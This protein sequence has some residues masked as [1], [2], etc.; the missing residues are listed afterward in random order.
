M[1]SHDEFAIA[2]LADV[3]QAFGAGGRAERLPSGEG[4]AFR[5]G[6]LVLKP[7][8]EP[9]EA[10][11]IGNVLED[12]TEKAHQIYNTGVVNTFRSQNAAQG[13]VSRARNSF[14]PVRRMHADEVDTDA[15]LVRR[16]LGAQFPQWA[17]L[18]IMRV[19]SAGTDNAIYR[20]GDDMSV[21]L[22]RIEW[23]T[24]QIPK[25]QHWLP[26]LA[27]HLPVAIP[28]PL[29]QGEPAEGY[30]WTWAVY[31]WLDGENALLEDL[32]DPIAAATA[33]AQF[34]TA[35]QRVDTTGAPLATELP[36]LR[37]APLPSRDQETRAA[38][39]ELEGMYDVD[40][41]TTVWER[42]LAAPPWDRPP[43]WF[44]GD[45]LPGN[46]LF[47]H[48]VLCAVIDFSGLGAGDPACDLM[49]AWALFSGES[50]AAFRAALDLDDATWI[51]ARGHAV[52]Q[53]AQFIPYYLDTNPMGVERARHSLEAALADE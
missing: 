2:P 24:E 4:R 39:A 34:V 17:E 35:L 44:H 52:S 7:T 40:A 41:M 19:E 33:L 11:W 50:R 15:S 8:P 46:L 13:P 36:R 42:A 20:L 48:G 10:E 49:S 31:R 37:G 26:P 28:V 32:A 30:P 43:V 6:R 29:A 47:D 14:V 21:R 38:I 16:L 3:Q 22:P 27:A 5:I 18:P 25:E 51:R 1:K 53:A 45:L 23:A 9:R 12:V